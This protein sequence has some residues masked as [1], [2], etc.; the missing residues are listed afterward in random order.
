[1]WKSPIL[2]L[3]LAL[4]KSNSPNPGFDFPPGSGSTTAR[5]GGSI[6]SRAALLLK[7]LEADVFKP[8][9]RAQEVSRQS[10]IADAGLTKNAKA[11]S[12]RL[13]AARAGE[14]RAIGFRDVR[15]RLAA[16][17]RRRMGTTNLARPGGT[18]PYGLKATFQRPA[19]MVSSC[20]AEPRCGY[21]M[22]SNLRPHSSSP[23]VRVDQRPTRVQRLITRQTSCRESQLA[24]RRRC[25]AGLLAQD[26]HHDFGALGD[27]YDHQLH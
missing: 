11:N 16:E 15:V 18:V 22:S 7:E 8:G 4:R 1:M 6:G 14:G 13:T 3:V 10:W 5:G 23:R 20:D 9:R 21:S 27:L 26:V 12:P 2:P 17:A 19:Q 24:R 25:G